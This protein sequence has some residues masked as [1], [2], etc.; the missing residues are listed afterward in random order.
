[1]TTTTCKVRGCTDSVHVIKDKLCQKHYLRLRRHGD[2]NYTGN[3]R[4]DKCEA[5]RAGGSR[6]KNPRSDGQPYCPKHRKMLDKT[7]HLNATDEELRQYCTRPGCKSK[8]TN[9]RGLCAEHLEEERKRTGSSPK[10]NLKGL[11]VFQRRWLYKQPCAVCG[12][13]EASRDV[14]H[15]T[16]FDPDDPE[17]SNRLSNLVVLCPNC[18]RKAHEGKLAKKKLRE[19]AQAMRKKAPKKH[20]ACP[21]CGERFATPTSQSRHDVACTKSRGLPSSRTLRRRRAQ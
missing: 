8:R 13:D 11:P 9:R 7:G 15:M 19:C 16:A 4:Q 12:W 3:R 6:C 18:H 5:T 1:M 2:V 20:P 17:H 14:H 21:V 10:A